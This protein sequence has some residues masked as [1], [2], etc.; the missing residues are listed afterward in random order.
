MLK[1]CLVLWQSN[2]C[3]LG[4]NCQN[5]KSIFMIS[6]FKVLLILVYCPFNSCFTFI[7]KEKLQFSL[8]CCLYCCLVKECW[9]LKV[10][11]QF[12]IRRLV[13]YKT[14]AYK[15]SLTKTTYFTGYAEN[16]PLAVRDNTLD[17]I[18]GFKEI[19]VK[20]VSNN[21]MTLNTGKYHIPQNR[22]GRNTIKI[23]GL[24]ITTLHVKSYYT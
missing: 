6:D 19:L 24:Y 8:F 12:A 11:L 7:T 13:A 20:C 17:V 16:T 2:L 15:K 23:G 9:A 3:L 4:I 10:A 5:S 14:V 18:K 1:S 21:Q 22:S